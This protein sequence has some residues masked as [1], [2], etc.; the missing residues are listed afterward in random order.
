MPSHKTAS[1]DIFLYA[2]HLTRNRACTTIG[3]GCGSLPSHTP[4]L[5]RYVESPW[6]WSG[7]I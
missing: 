1:L 4:N 3:S 5:I 2:K 6:H 7:F